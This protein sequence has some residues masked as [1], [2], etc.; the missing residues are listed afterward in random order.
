MDFD[1]V[2]LPCRRKAMMIDDLAVS[3]VHSRDALYL[4]R[5]Q[6]KVENIQIFCHSGCVDGFGNGGDTSLEMPPKYDL[7]GCPAV[8]VRNFGQRPVMENVLLGLRK[9]SP[10]LGDNAIILHDPQGGVLLEK[11]MDFN[12]LTM[13]LIS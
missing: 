12:L 6:F 7:G 1:T 11:W 13:G 5:G 8:L 2:Q 9:R 10:S 4:L 3:D